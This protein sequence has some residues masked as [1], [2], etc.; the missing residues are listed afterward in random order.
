[1]PF[2]NPIVAGTTLVRP[3]IRSPNYVTGISGWTI[4]ADGSAEFNN[5]V[6]RGTVIASDFQSSNY[7]A[8]TTGFDINGITGLVQFNG[9]VVV[10]GNADFRVQAS[11]APTPTVTITNITAANPAVFTTSAAHNFFAGEQILLQTLVG[12]AGFTVNTPYYVVSPTVN[13]F[14]L[15]TTLGGAGLAAT[16]VGSGTYRILGGYIELFPT[17]WAVNSPTINLGPQQGETLPGQLVAEGIFGFNAYQIE[18]SAP[19][20]V[21]NGQ[22]SGGFFLVYSGDKNNGLYPGAQFQCQGPAVSGA[23]VGQVQVNS[24]MQLLALATGTSALQAPGRFGGIGGNNLVVHG[25]G[26]DAASGNSLNQTLFLNNNST[27]GC[28]S[29]HMRTI[30]ARNTGSATITATSPTNTLDAPVT[31]ILPPSGT[32]LISHQ[33]TIVYPGNSKEFFQDFYINNNTSA[34]QVYGPSVN[35][36]IAFNGG[37]ATPTIR[38][39]ATSVAASALGNPGDSITIGLAQWWLTAGT[40]TAQQAWLSVTPSL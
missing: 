16:T 26:I 37:T 18:L 20:G 31:M 10:G 35:N 14:R 13:T 11:G 7:V 6:I 27:L 19:T 24:N 21:D 29:A 22:A 34:T 3:A 1:M 36:G 23:I 9:S 28:A 25:F 40:A 32:L 33:V 30:G 12:G 5:V 17:A 38:L 8:N 39:S 4:N 2:N 15:S